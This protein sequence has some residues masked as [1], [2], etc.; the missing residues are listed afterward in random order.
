M[1]IND[2]PKSAIAKTI[3]MY[4]IICINNLKKIVRDF[5]LIF[6]IDLR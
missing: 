6:Y 3:S 5:Q 1:P 2:K 4:P